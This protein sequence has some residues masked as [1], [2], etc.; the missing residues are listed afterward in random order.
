[1]GLLK[2]KHYLLTGDRIPAAECV[3]LGLA[4]KAVPDDQLMDEAMTMAQR[5][6]T[7]PPQAIQETKRAINLHLQA[8]ISLVA[9]FA[10]SAEAKSFATDE[11][12]QTIGKFKQG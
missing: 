7:Q 12:R 3:E 2:A 4:T 1:M 6:A 5:L 9:P 11:L 10:L 8:A